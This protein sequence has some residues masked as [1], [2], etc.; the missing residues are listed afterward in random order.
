MDR[1]IKLLSW[2]IDAAVMSCLIYSL[3]PDGAFQSIM[4]GIIFLLT[5]TAIWLGRN[6]KVKGW[7]QAL[8]GTRKQ[9]ILEIIAYGIFIAIAIY[10]NNTEI[11]ITAGVLLLATSLAFL[12]T[13]KN[14][15]SMQ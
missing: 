7:A 9:N 4:M 10:L 5:L 3:L 13:P 11:A 12:P 1:Q 2:N 6:V 15:K 8:T 14:R